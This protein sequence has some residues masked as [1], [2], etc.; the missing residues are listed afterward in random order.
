[1]SDFEK[2]KV[3]TILGTR[4]E[5]IRLSRVISKLENNLSHV[6]YSAI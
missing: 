3:L 2:I 1:M 6:L 4:P 5:M